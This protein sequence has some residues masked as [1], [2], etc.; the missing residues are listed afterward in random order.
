MV[1]V[2]AITPS[3]PGFHSTISSQGWQSLRTRSP[4]PKESST[5]SE[6]FFRPSAR[7]VSSG[8]GFQSI[9]RTRQLLP[10]KEFAV[11]SLLRI[12]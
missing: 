2:R 11:V 4:I 6:M 10:L 9:S 3:L 5:S 7:P 8:A 1:M 12:C